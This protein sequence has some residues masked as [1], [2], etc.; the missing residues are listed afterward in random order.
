MRMHDGGGA[1]GQGAHALRPMRNGLQGRDRR[2]KAA[3]PA[4]PCQFLSYHRLCLKAAENTP[5]HF[6]PAPNP[7]V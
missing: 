6:P 4:L 7:P 1:R 5:S 2:C 3:L